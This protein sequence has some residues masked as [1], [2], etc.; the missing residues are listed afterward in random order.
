MWGILGPYSA[1]RLKVKGCKVRLAWLTQVR[2]LA[3]RNIAYRTRSWFWRLIFLGYLKELPASQAIQLQVMGWRDCRGSGR[4]QSWYNGNN[5]LIFAWRDW[6]KP[7]KHQ[8]GHPESRL[9][10]EPGTSLIQAWIINCSNL[11]VYHDVDD[12]NPTSW[13]RLTRDF[14]SYPNIF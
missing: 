13:I 7:V 11:F 1:P 6:G 8:L 9:E 12:A 5:T 2:I 3:N 14:L 4:K 10:F